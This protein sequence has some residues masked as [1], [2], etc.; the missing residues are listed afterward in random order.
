M[1]P[2]IGGEEIGD[3]NG[4]ERQYDVQPQHVQMVRANDHPVL[5]ELAV[6]EKRNRNK[7]EDR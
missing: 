5:L 7:Y 1:M 6:K 4:Q 2:A 3:A